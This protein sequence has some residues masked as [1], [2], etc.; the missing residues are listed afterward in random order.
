MHQFSKFTVSNRSPSCGVTRIKAHTM[1][2]HQR[3]VRIRDLLQNYAP[4]GNCC[5]QGLFEEY[6]FTSL[7]GHAHRLHMLVISGGN[8]HR[9]HINLIQ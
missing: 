4:V 7:S 1:A 5:G 6:G 9:V 3:H 2:H 8:D